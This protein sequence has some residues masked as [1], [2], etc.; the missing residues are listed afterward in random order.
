VVFETCVNLDQKDVLDFAKICF[1][2]RKGLQITYNAV[3]LRK[4]L[5]TRYG[6]VG[7]RFL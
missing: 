4:M 2:I 6:L 7:N 3:V 5:G 1:K